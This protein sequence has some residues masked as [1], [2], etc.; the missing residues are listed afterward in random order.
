MRPVSRILLL[1]AAVL[2]A[3]CS[4]PSG[5]ENFVPR[6]SVGEDGRYCFSAVMTD[7][8]AS[9]SLRLYTRTDCSDR[10]FAAMRDMGMDVL[11]VAPSGKEYSERVY[12]PKSSFRS[13]RFP[14]HDC[15]VPYRTGF[16]PAESGIWKIYLK[17][18]PETEPAGLRG[19]GLSISKKKNGKR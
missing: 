6:D 14:A 9:Y 17:P 4:E 15:D 16:R 5:R 8:L 10:E 12:I 1:V 2:C 18:V 11:A 13:G 7:T 19:M 3:A